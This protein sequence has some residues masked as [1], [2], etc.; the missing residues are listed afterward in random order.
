MVATHYYLV[1]LHVAGHTFEYVT[2]HEYVTWTRRCFT[3][4]HMLYEHAHASRCFSNASMKSPSA[5]RARLSPSRQALEFVVM[6]GINDM[7]D[8][9]DMDGMKDMNKL[10]ETSLTHHRNITKTSLLAILGFWCCFL[11]LLQCFFK[12]SS[13]RLNCAAHNINKLKLKWTTGKG[14]LGTFKIYETYE[15]E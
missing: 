13:T 1:W 10:N 14:Q 15:V 4:T 5:S 3:N 9:E 2:V 7:D 8:T 12:H 6:K 11:M